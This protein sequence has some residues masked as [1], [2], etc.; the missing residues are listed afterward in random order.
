MK[1]VTPL[2]LGC[3]ILLAAAQLSAAD[4][5]PAT[6]QLKLIDWR[7]QSQ[8]VVKQTEILQPRFPVI[9]IHNHLGDITQAKAFIAEMD[10][11]GVKYCVNL[12]GMSADDKWAEDLEAYAP[13]GGRVWTFFS[14]DFSG[15]DEP[16]WGENEAAKLEKAVKAGCRGLKIFKSLGLGA[17]GKDGKL[18]KVDDPRIDPVWH[19]CGELGIPVMIHVSDPKAFF[20]PVDE[21]NERYDELGAHPDWS[22]YGPEWPS[23]EELLEARNRVIA[24][25]PETIFIGAHVGNLPEELHTV[26]KWLDV[27]PNFYVDI[28]ARISELGRQPYTARDFIIKYQDRIMFGTD[29]PPDAGAYQVYYRFLE[30]KDEYID[31]AAGHHLQG[32]WMING[33]HLPDEVLKKLYWN[34]AARLMGIKPLDDGAG[35]CDAAATNCR[36]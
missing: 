26:G 32:R 19:M 16:G 30:T 3:G 12:D 4:Q 27:Y 33:L 5:V 28:D 14:P 8:M 17:R 23:K 25:H 31:P 10:R 15:I 11:A 6:G 24:R 21:H 18:I 9:D 36:D 35:C 22:F 29:T 2:A 34:N 1:L 7:P 20:T 13:F